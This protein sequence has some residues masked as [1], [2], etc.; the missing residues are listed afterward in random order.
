MTG[1]V[2]GSSGAD[3]MPASMIVGE[4]GVEENPGPIELGR[5]SK[6]RRERGGDRTLLVMLGAQT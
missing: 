2:G 5:V 1:D 3:A 4:G 6:F